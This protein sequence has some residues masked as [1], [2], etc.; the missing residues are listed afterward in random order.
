MACRPAQDQAWSLV[1][2][3]AAGG[4][5]PQ[6]PKARLT[7]KAPGSLKPKIQHHLEPGSAS[8][9]SPTT[10]CLRHSAHPLQ[11]VLE[12]F[13]PEGKSSQIQRY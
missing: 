6:L 3:R 7:G 8:R 1:G 11:S 2:P 5:R 10:R 13:D 12:L 9:D 4:S